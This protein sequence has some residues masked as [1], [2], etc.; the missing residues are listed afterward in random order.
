MRRAQ[1][2]RRLD[3]GPVQSSHGVNIAAIALQQANRWQ[4]LREL[5]IL[6]ELLGIWIC[7]AKDSV[8]LH[9]TIYWLLGRA[10]HLAFHRLRLDEMY[11]IPCLAQ[12]NHL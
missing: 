2:A 7:A 6:T 9:S 8:L 12:L 3:I 10:R 11:C 4:Q 5:K 1:Q